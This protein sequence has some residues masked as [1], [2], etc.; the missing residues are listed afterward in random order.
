ML[1]TK[2]CQHCGTQLINKRP[3]S[4]T[5][6]S[7]CRWRLFDTKHSQVVPV[8]LSFGV[9]HFSAVKNAAAQRG[10]TVADYIMS[11]VTES[12]IRIGMTIGC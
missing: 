9:H 4:K 7:T 11:R 6:S 12:D 3:H 10:L 5:C 2:L 1:A 8:K